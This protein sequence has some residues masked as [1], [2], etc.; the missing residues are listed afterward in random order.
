MAQPKWVWIAGGLAVLF[1]IGV[2]NDD[3]SGQG[4][5]PATTTTAA[6]GEPTA[7][8]P[9]PDEGSHDE[10]SQDEGSQDAAPETCTVPDVVGMVHQQA[11]DTMQDA[12]LFQLRE[13]DATGRGRMLI[14]DR[15]WTTTAQS[16]AAGQVVAC[17]TE[18]TLAAR[19]TDE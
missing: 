18:I 19:K 8:P 11:Q 4:D 14:V 6:V 16:V 3:G 13:E 9:P 12:G 1:V 5:A 7:A 10:G 15:N 17:D 2:V